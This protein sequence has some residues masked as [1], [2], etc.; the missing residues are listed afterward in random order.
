M[1]QTANMQTQFSSLLSKNAAQVDKPVTSDTSKP[2]FPFIP[3]QNVSFDGVQDANLFLNSLERH[4]LQ[5]QGYYD[6]D[7]D[8]I[9]R[10]WMVRNHLL[11]PAAR[12]YDNT[13]HDDTN[14]LGNLDTVQGRGSGINHAFHLVVSYT[15]SASRRC[16]IT[17]MERTTSQKVSTDALGGYLRLHRS[18]PL[19]NQ[20]HVRT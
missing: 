15:A 19:R 11:G 18:S 14:A 6:N 10:V 1:Q 20:S 7:P 5:N 8:N 12:C 16:F 3:L 17:G 13:P 2:K 4:Y 9:Q